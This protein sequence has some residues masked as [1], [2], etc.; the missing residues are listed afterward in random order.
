MTTQI[1]FEGDPHLHSDVVGAVKDS[2]VVSLF[3]HDDGQGGSR[4]TCSY[5][6]VLTAAS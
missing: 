1:Y 6:F 2:L 4:A 5:D 3:H